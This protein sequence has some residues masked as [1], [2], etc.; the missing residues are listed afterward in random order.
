MPG[1]LEYFSQMA[2]QAAKQITGSNQTW[3]AFLRSVGRFYKY[4]YAEQVMIH[5]QRPDATACADYDFW[6]DKMGRY[7]RRGSKGIALIDSSGDSPRLRYVFD[8]SD[9]GAR[10]RSRSV[11]LW[12]LSEGMEDGVR[13]MFAEEYGLDDSQDLP[14]QIE[15]AAATLADEAWEAN[16][17]DIADI[18]ANS[19]LDGYD[20]SEAGISFRGA[21]AVSA[22]YAIL[23][24][25]GLAPERYFSPDDFMSVFDWNTPE[26]AAA[27]GTAVSNISE[28]VLRSIEI[29]SSCVMPSARLRPLG[30]NLANIVLICN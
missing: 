16:K 25:C 7:V 3:T 22:A 21:V 26:T 27:I 28:Q 2:E 1:K 29:C 14:E 5:A 23:S 18:L 11:N 20:E 17:R 19:F 8:V 9:T 12:Q 13:Q 24:R 30:M 6:K 4:P 15:V 10:P